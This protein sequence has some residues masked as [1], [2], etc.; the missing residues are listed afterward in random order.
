MQA[1]AGCGKTVLARKIMAY[2]RS[3]GYLAYG[4]ASTAL[5][6]A[7]LND[8][9]H[10][11]HS[12]FKFPVEEDIDDTDDKKSTLQCQLSKFVNEERY[13]SLK[14][15]TLI[16]WDEMPSNHRIILESLYKV[17]D[18]LPN[19][20]LLCLGDFRQILPIVGNMAA[21]SSILDA[22]I[23][24]S[25]LWRLFKVHIMTKNLRLSTCASK[26]D[27]IRQQEY[28]SLILSIGNGENIESNYF[29]VTVPPPIEHP[30]DQFDR[31][32][33][34]EMLNDT[35]YYRI[36]NIPMFVEDTSIEEQVK[37]NTI[38]TSA[39]S[40]LQEL[41]PNGLEGNVACTRFI[42]AATNDRIDYWN[43]QVQLLNRDNAFF[44]TKY[45]TDQIMDSDD[46]HGYLSQMV[47]CHAVMEK[48]NATEVPPYR[49]KLKKNDICL[50]LVN[51]SKSGGLTKNTRV[52]IVAVK[53]HTIDVETLDGKHLI[54][55]PRLRFEFSSRY[56][57]SFRMIRKQFPLRL[58][59]CMT[60]NKSQGQS[61][62]SILMDIV[63][64]PFAHGHLYVAI[65]RVRYFK[66]L[67][68]YCN[69]RQAVYDKNKKLR[70]VIIPSIT[71]KEVLPNNNRLTKN[72]YATR[73]QFSEYDDSDDDDNSDNDDNNNDN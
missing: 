43:T 17:M 20:V 18:K 58:A 34:T 41:F 19:T 28:S 64:P 5:A 68:I 33:P 38:C 45:S 27:N 67:K 22:C 60:Y 51:Y 35:H 42:V 49:L 37:Q 46:P 55:L 25:P 12:L 1:P 69:K 50:L 9:W 26:T 24:S 57:K 23:K 16:I 32:I 44:E 47:R 21:K 54:P 66:G 53:K 56:G 13:K 30:V 40:A 59:Y 73:I 65:S 2:A 11:A 71:H 61:A 14:E 63:N 36:K 48:Y 29:G 15:T 39:E 3:K 52:K 10:T 72:D 6:A 8:N 31:A 4:C 7:S 62:D 70:S